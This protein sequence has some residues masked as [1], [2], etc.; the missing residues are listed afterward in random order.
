MVH[1]HEIRRSYHVLNSKQAT[2]IR[3]PP[4]ILAYPSVQA[5]TA[6]SAMVNRGGRGGPQTRLEGGRV[7][8]RQ[9][10]IRRPEKMVMSRYPQSSAT[11][12]VA[13]GIGTAAIGLFFILYTLYANPGSPN[14]PS[15]LAFVFGLA[16]LLGGIT[17][18]F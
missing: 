6:L 5:F 10:P 2:I 3:N 8:D 15:W 7:T 11:L 14:E 1:S 17:V 9:S 4:K 18:V 12:S 13:L 16:F